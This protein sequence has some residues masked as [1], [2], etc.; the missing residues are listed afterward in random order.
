MFHG[1]DSLDP[2]RFSRGGPLF[3]L[4]PIPADT[5]L[6]FVFLILHLSNRL[7]S[8]RSDL[9]FPD[10]ALPMLFLTPRYY[11][12]Q[13]SFARGPLW[14]ISDVPGTQRRPTKPT[15][16][17]RAYLSRGCPLFVFTRGRDWNAPPHRVFLFLFYCVKNI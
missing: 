11:H 14:M 7:R 6:L 1:N 4:L 8:H 16:R 10:H 13:F 12:M 9:S 15:L 17:S 3:F 2:V 5:P